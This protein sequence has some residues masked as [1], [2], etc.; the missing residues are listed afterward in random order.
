MPVGENPS[1]VWITG[2]WA[3]DNTGLDILVNGTSTGQTS[4]GFG[5]LTPFSLTRGFVNGLN[6]I[7]FYVQGN[8]VTDGFALQLES[9]TATAVP[10]PGALVALGA[11]GA[12]GSRRRRK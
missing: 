6:T 5:T 2:D 10:A 3:T 12:L 11:A 4:P 9:F 8:G 7:D 1:S